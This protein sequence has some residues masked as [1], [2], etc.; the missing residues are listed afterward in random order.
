MH[1]LG[2]EATSGGSSGTPPRRRIGWRW[3]WIVIDVGLVALCG[4]LVYKLVDMHGG[5]GTSEVKPL[6]KMRHRDFTVAELREY[7]GVH[8]VNE[9]NR[10]LV[11]INGVVFDV[12]NVGRQYYGPGGPY[13]MFAGRDASRALAV[14]SLT[15]DAI[16]DTYDD[17]ADLSDEQRK[18]VVEWESTFRE[19]YDAVGR[20]L[21][22][23]ERH[24]VYN[25]DGSTSAN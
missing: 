4:C 15:D 6:P 3:R 16:R 17:L 12:S 25:D 20:L 7:D 19:K 8:N 9:A 22:T 24:A 11:A 23:G 10:I 2:G 5:W 1:V 14:W 21:K 18:I 13:A